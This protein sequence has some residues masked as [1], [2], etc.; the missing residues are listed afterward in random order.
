MAEKGRI[1]SENPDIMDIIDAVNRGIDRKKQISYKYF[2]IDEN[3]EPD[4]RY[5]GSSVRISPYDFLWIDDRYYLIG[6]SISHKKVITIR[7]DRMSDVKVTNDTS[8]PIP[9]SYNIDNYI[10][11]VFKMF[12]GTMQTV[13]LKCKKKEIVNSVVDKFGTDVIIEQFDDENTYYIT[14]KVSVSKT[15]F[16]WVFQFGEEIEIVSPKSARAEFKKMCQNMLKLY[17]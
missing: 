14:V 8:V 7:V 17:K 15:F 1:K 16:S 2:D 11:H 12:D 10:K 4:Y 3:L 9:D 6:F 5:N 13:E